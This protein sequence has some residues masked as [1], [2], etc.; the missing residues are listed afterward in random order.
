MKEA[1]PCCRSDRSLALA[2]RTEMSTG[3]PTE[4]AA[5]VRPLRA[6]NE[7]DS[8]VRRIAAITP[9]MVCPKR[10]KLRPASPA[11]RESRDNIAKPTRLGKSPDRERESHG[12]NLGIKALLLPFFRKD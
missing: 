9:D 11:G 1:M 4:A 3:P 12:R 7:H 2:G 8:R 10:T 5:T 6:S